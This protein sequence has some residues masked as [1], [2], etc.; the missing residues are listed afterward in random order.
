MLVVGWMAPVGFAQ[1]TKSARGTVTAI[2]ADSLT[3]KAADSEMRFTVEREDSARRVGRRHGGSQGRGRRQAGSAAHRLRE[4][5]RQ[6][7]GQLYRHGHRD[8]RDL[9]DGDTAT[10]GRGGGART[11]RAITLVSRLTV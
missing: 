8:A 3:V 9:G 1:D 11:E 6:R 4:G 5:R 10:L 7:R 2:A